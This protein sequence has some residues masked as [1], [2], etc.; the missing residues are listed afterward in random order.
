MYEIVKEL[1]LIIIFFN[2]KPIKGINGLHRELSVVLSLYSRRD[3]EALCGGG[4]P[5]CPRAILFN[6]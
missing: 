4:A 3:S 6:P 1:A 5:S 2:T